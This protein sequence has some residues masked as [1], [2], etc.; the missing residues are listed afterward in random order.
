MDEKELKVNYDPS[1]DVAYFSY[2]EPR[3]A[4]SFEAEEGVVVRLDPITNK[5][6]GFTVVNFLRRFQ[7]DPG[8]FIS[9]PT[10]TVVSEPSARRAL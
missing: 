7:K 2:G 6:I 1:A 3:E 9:L 10:S 4:L 5:V 8:T